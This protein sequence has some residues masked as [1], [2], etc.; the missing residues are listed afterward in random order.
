MC[1]QDRMGVLISRYLD[2]ELDAAQRE[3]VRDHLRLCESCRDFHDVAAKNDEIIAHAVQAHFGEN[4]TL[5][6]MKKIKVEAPPR[7]PARVT[8]TVRPR[9]LAMA[10]GVLV[11]IFA[12]W[13]VVQ[14]H[15]VSELAYET[16]LMREN[17]RGAED[18]ARADERRRQALTKLLLD[19]LTESRREA[20]HASIDEFADTTDEIAAAYISSGV[21]VT[22]RFPDGLGCAFY[23][24]VRRET[25]EAA[26]SRPLN[27]VRLR[28]PEFTD[29]TANPGAAYEYVFIGYSD[30]GRHESLPVRVEV[31]ADLHDLTWEVSCREVDPDNGAALLVV[32]RRGLAES[33]RV[34]IGETAGA[35]DFATGY[36]LER[37]EEGDETLAATVAWPLE[38]EQGRRVYDPK[39]GKPKVRLEEMLLSVRQN[40]RVVLRGPDGSTVG[41]WRQGRTEIPVAEP[42]GTR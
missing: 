12:G 6:V 25:G 29:L 13:A 41:V 2:D 7:P 30:R 24:I 22:A 38:D 40:K 28:K 14:N 5:A 37:I 3:S 36:T 20:T 23:D 31:P 42:A 35:G 26:F 21:T 9:H 11:S 27:G 17:A 16:A 1:C 10:A 32:I 34:R 19:D 39:T 33:F 4:L 8:F 18:R 15:R